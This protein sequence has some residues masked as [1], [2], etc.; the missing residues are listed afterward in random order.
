MT[1]VK[2]FDRRIFEYFLK[3]TYAI[4]TALSLFVL[5][6]DIPI[7]SKPTYG[8]IFLVL[9][10]LIY[11]GIWFWSNNL[12]TIN[13]NIEGSDVTIKVGDIFKQPG[14]KA[15]AF[16]EYFDTQVENKII[17]EESLNGIYIKKYL[18]VPVSEL[19]HHI[20]SYDFDRSEILENNS[21]RQLGKKVRHQI[22]TICVYK[23]YL[24]TAFSK[25]NEKNRA[26][27]TMPEYLEFLINFWDNVNNVYGQ[28]NVSTAIFGSGI[29]R[30]KGHKN[31]SDED[32]LKIMLWTFR[33]SEMRFKYPAKLTIVIHKDKIDKINLLEIKAARN[34]I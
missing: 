22:G 9:L 15:I 18:D 1:K 6:I 16:N 14:L 29:T 25:F 31:I 13:I 32:L 28:Q 24:L 4:S 19:D 3:T 34:G 7:N 10:A 33:I 26:Q 20:E 8:W 27:L 5:F 2:F 23:D 21:D 12:N 30:I 17:A 11:V